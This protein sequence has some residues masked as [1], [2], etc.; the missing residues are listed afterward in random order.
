MPVTN[1]PPKG[2]PCILQVNNSGAWKNVCHY[3]EAVA[4]QAGRV[5]E[6]AYSLQ[7]VNDRARFRI[8]TDDRKQTVIAWLD[9]LFWKAAS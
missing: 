3:D 6:A 2:K 7:F 5:R 4:D 9:N 8:A 1:T